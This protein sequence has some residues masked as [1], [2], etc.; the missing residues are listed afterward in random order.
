M[1][2]SLQE[3]SALTHQS[4]GCQL[5]G[6]GNAWLAET[7]EQFNSGCVRAPGSLNAS[8]WIPDADIDDDD[9]EEAAL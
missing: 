2:K 7:L 6:N 4:P 9:G 5:R 8:D 1:E 3:P